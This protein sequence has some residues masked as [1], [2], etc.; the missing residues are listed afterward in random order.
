MSMTAAMSSPQLRDMDND[1]TLV[2]LAAGDRPTKLDYLQPLGRLPMHF[3][4]KRNVKQNSELEAVR[5]SSH[6]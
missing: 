1:D 6:I 2:V 4:A 5:F 3:I